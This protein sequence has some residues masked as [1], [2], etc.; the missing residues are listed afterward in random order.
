VLP[1]LIAVI[2]PSSL[3]RRRRPSHRTRALNFQLLTGRRRANTPTEWVPRDTLQST[4]FL[5]ERCFSGKAR[6]NTGI[7][8]GIR[9]GCVCTVSHRRVAAK[10]NINFHCSGAT[11]ISVDEAARTASTTTPGAPEQTAPFTAE[12]TLELEN[13]TRRKSAQ[14]PCAAVAWHA[15]AWHACALD[16]VKS[17]PLRGGCMQIMTPR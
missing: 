6:W 2:S 11:A 16:P 1:A 10:K 13:K 3:D 17:Y 5:A 8:G 7:V 9:D 12:N 4:Q 15:W 14:Q